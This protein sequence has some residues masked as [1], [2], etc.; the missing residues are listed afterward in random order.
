MPHSILDFGEAR[1]LLRDSDLER[2][3]VL[4][5]LLRA[6]G[7]TVIETDCSASAIACLEQDTVSLVMAVAS[8]SNTDAFSLSAM[9]SGRVA[10][11]T[12]PVLIMLDREDAHVCDVA[13][14][15]GAADLIMLPCT[16]AWLLSRIRHHLM[17][18]KTL[19]DLRRSQIA[20]SHAERLALIGSWEWDTDSNE[21][22]WSDE[23]YRVWGTS[24]AK[25]R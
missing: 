16:G 3:R 7:A 23:T 19:R 2:R 1:I 8:S 20:H 18:A 14:H 11:D 9:I 24:P 13:H 17:L 15:T 21:M 22:N 25:S 10:W 12:P 6:E 5:T 4:A